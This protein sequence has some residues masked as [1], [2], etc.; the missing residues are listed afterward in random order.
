MKFVNSI[1]PIAGLTSALLCPLK[2]AVVSY[3]FNSQVEGDLFDG[4]V[5]GWTQDSPNPRAFG[6]TFPLAYISTINFSGPGS[7]SSA[8]FL[9]TFLGNTSDNSPTTLTG[10]LS[11]AGVM[12]SSSSVSMSLGIVDDSADQFET[13]DEFSVIL[14]NSGSGEAAR[15][16]LVPDVSNNTLWNVS[17]GVN[18]SPAVTTSASLE[19]GFGYQIAFEFEDGQTNFLYRSSVSEGAY[20][21]LGSLGPVTFGD[22]ESIQ[23]THTPQGTAGSSASALVFDN[24]VAVPEPSAM[25]LL[26]L[27]LMGALGRR[28]R[29]GR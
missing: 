20:L 17:I 21:D 5:A 10:D 14:R 13:R 24:I 19:A 25:S 29:P 7:G 22:F 1:F 6:T 27:G 23:F 12:G 28:H 18:G 8:G 11:G 9:G 2:G 4:A 15:I 16:D 3:D 26:L